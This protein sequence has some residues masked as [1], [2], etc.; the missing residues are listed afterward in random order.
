MQEK[1]YEYWPNTEGGDT[2]QNYGEYT[3]SQQRRIVMPEWIQT[4]LALKYKKVCKIYSKFPNSITREHFW[5]VSWR[6][7][8]WFFFFFFHF[9]FFLPSTVLILMLTLPLLCE[10]SEIYL[11][12]QTTER[13]STLLVDF[14]AQ[15]RS[16]RLQNINQVYGSDSSCDGWECWSSCG[17]LQVH[18]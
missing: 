14:L 2:I 13:T 15:K 4:T 18:A 9:K 10:K 11:L 16:A 6:F 7:L 17:T 3:I 8:S 1:C 5:G 12:G